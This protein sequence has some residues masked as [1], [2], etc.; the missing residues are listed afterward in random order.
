MLSNYNGPTLIS[1]FQLWMMTFHRHSN[2]GYELAT[3]RTLTRV[4][5]RI[6]G[7]T[8]FKFFRYIRFHADSAACCGKMSEIFSDFP[9]QLLAMGKHY[10]RL[11]NW[12]RSSTM[13]VVKKFRWYNQ[14]FHPISPQ[15][16]WDKNLMKTRRIRDW[17]CH[18]QPQV[19]C[20][21][22]LFRSRRRLFGPL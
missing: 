9:F 11:H 13:F 19:A 4:V 5:S 12:Y 20:E 1:N 17:L 3:G 14:R 15:S 16:G 22:R 8:Q 21:K 18:F 6:A 10:T 2:H 7:R